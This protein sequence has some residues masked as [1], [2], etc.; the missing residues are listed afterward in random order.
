[1]KFWLNRRFFGFRS[2]EKIASNLVIVIPSFFILR[3]W[4]SVR[5][6]ITGLNIDGVWCIDEEV[7]KRE[8]Q[9]IFRALFQAN[10]PCNPHSLQLRVVPQIDANHCEDLLRLVSMLEVKN[11]VFSMSAYKALGPNGFQSIFFRT[12]WSMVAKDIWD[13]VSVAFSTG[14][15]DKQ[16]AETLIVPIPKVDDPMSL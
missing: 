13:L 12:Y 14:C 8:A 9:S 15:I 11:V 16:L 4:S 3:L 1:M 5:N 7:L 6:K 2:P 10:V